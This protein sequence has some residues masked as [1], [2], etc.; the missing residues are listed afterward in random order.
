MGVF[1]GSVFSF[2]TLPLAAIFTPSMAGDITV[3]SVLVGILVAIVGMFYQIRQGQREAKESRAEEI[4]S[5]VTEIINASPEKV[6][7]N[8]QP[9]IVKMQ[10]AFVT[11]DVVDEKFGH[12]DRRVAVLERH[13]EA[14]KMELSGKI[15]ALPARIIAMLSD[16]W[17]MKQG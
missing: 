10:E 6:V 2:Q 7:V 11:K 4:R 14:D 8:P 12:L 13:R 1:S 5:V 9:L 16:V 3:V 15:D 17:R